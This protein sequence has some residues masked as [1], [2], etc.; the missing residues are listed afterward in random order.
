MF[1]PTV[2]QYAASLSSTLSVMTTATCFAWME[3]LMSRFIGPDSEIPNLTTDDTSWLVASIEIGEVVATIPAGLLADRFGRKP[4]ILSTGPMS[5]VGWIL[6]LTTRNLVVLYVVRVIQGLVLAISFTVVP[7]YIAEIADPR[8][9]GELSGHFKTL[10]Y[11]GILYVYIIGPLFSYQTYIY[12]CTG[13]PIVFIVLYSFMPESPYYFC[14]RC[15]HDKAETALKWLR[16]TEDVDK[17]FKSISSSVEGEM[18]NKGSWRDLIATKADR[19]AFFIVQLVCCIKYLNGMPAVVAYA[20]ETF[21]TGSAENAHTLTIA[22]GVVL[23]LS[24]FGSAFISDSVGRRPLL[25]ISIAGSIFFNVLIATYYFLVEKTSID[26][27]DYYWIMFISLGGFCFS[28]NVGL[29]PLL[30]TMQAEYFPSNTRGLGGGITEMTA[31]VTTFINLKAYQM[32]TDYFGIYMNYVT[33]SFFGIVGFILLY[34]TCPET[35]GRSL[36][37][38]QTDLAKDANEVITGEQND[39]F[40]EESTSNTTRY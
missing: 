6:I 32:L 9:R 31:S 14:M 23:C 15:K 22:L 37:E 36:G 4:L 29:G 8:I 39:G 18:K 5:L 27:S 28:A 2:R 3:P 24:C 13:L 10:W 11:L 34:L 7:M 30:Q 21:K 25:L 19:K 20:T 40:D 17:E 26:V 38:I 1:G 35:A 12:L 33:F 16:A